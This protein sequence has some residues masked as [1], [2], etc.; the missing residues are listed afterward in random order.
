MHLPLF[1]DG[2]T[3]LSKDAINRC[4][5]LSTK[6]TSPVGAYT[7]DSKG[8]EY[9]RQSVADF[10]NKRDG[11][12]G[13]DASNANKIYIGNGASEGARISL[14]ACIRNDSDG[15]LVPIPLYPLYSAQLALQKGQLLPY[16]LNEEENWSI[17]IKQIEA[18]IEH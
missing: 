2:S 17:D 3:A 1:A 4:K 14:L 12:K 7:G 18:Q 13:E 10:I 15:V 8:Y 6:C 9:V 5:I 11:L 16:F